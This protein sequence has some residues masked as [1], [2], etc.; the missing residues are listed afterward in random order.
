[1]L[2]SLVIKFGFEIYDDYRVVK[3]YNNCYTNKIPLFSNTC[4]QKYDWIFYIGT[5]RFNTACYFAHKDLKFIWC[6]NE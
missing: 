1:M 6:E 3:T 4:P 5:F 2:L